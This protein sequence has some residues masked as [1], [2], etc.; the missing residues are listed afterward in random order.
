MVQ[1]ASVTPGIHGLSKYA[2]IE[3]ATAASP[4]NGRNA[5]T[6]LGMDDAKDPKPVFHYR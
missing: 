4:S 6:V 3:V 1:A 2:A 5:A